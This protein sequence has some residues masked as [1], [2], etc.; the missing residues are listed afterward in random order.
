[1]RTL[2]VR[3]AS[4]RLIVPASAVEDARPESTDRSLDC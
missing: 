4:P 3:G 2:A 1:M